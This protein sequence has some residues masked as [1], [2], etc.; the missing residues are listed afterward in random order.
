MFYTKIHHGLYGRQA[1]L[2]ELQAEMKQTEDVQSMFSFAPNVEKAL[3]EFRIQSEQYSKESSYN[4]IQFIKVGFRVSLL[5]R[6]LPKEVHQIMQA[7]AKQHNFD[8]AQLADM[9]KRYLDYREK[10]L[11]YLKAVRDAAQFSTYERLFSWWHVFHIPLVYMMVFSA[12]YHV[13]A[14]HAY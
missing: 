13:Y 12:F 1:T 6:S 3:E 5:S 10:I 9:E 2:N 8:G 7:Q 4:F 11:S 14:V